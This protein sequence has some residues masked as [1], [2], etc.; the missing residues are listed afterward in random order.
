[1]LHVLLL[2][3]DNKA[4]NSYEKLHDNFNH[5]GPTLLDGYNFLNKK[6]D[7]RKYSLQGCNILCYL[8]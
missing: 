5:E 8:Y 2:D 3:D 7:L 4:K 6:L 1:M